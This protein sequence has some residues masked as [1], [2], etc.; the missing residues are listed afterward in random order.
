[1]SL[2]FA[3]PA[4][5]AALAAVMVPILLHLARREE[6]RI[7]TFAALRWLRAGA[8]P[9]SRLQFDEL[10]LLLVRVLL[11]AA[12]ALW[13]AQPLLDGVIGRLPAYVAIA[14]GVPLAEVERLAPAGDDV[15]RHRLVE[16]FP[17]F[18]PGESERGAGSAGTNASDA[19]SVSSLLR[20]LD[21]T[22]PAGQ[23]LT[24]VV[25]P[26]IGGLDAERPVL[27]RKVTWLVAAQ[28]TAES[29][30]RG[31]QVG[32]GANQANPERPAAPR[33][34]AVRHDA[35]SQRAVRYVQASVA[36][37]NTE[38]PGAW[39]LDTAPIDAPIGA[40][41]QHVIVMAAA[42]PRAAREVA[43]RGGRVVHV[44]AAP[45]EG[46]MTSTRREGGGTLVALAQPLTPAHVPSLLDATFPAQ[47]RSWV[48]GDP[49]PPARAT[50]SMIEPV[51]GESGVAV[52]RRP[53]AEPIAWLIVALLALERWF[54]TRR[55]RF[56]AVA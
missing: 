29:P 44:P 8:R 37:W 28:G 34:L 56:K 23:P 27:S 15:E 46:A 39:V 43:A 33:K 6:T 4:M 16:T 30:A 54:A 1:M 55:R 10:W 24:V 26:E 47:L 32:T 2:A 9:T 50:A 20:E 48:E 7:E 45:R 25:P 3:V 13:L 53:L 18:D 35:E 52:Q 17:A 40:D 38:T 22:L 21:A 19:A 42:I 5:L 12:I 36:A 31:A 41:V 49:K 51:V 14:P 11:V